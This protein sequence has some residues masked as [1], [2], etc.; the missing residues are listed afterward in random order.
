VFKA[1]AP[2]PAA[3]DR[4]GD[5]QLIAPVAS[6]GMA[7]VWAAQQVSELPAHRLVAIK[8]MRGELG[9]DDDARRMFLD[10]GR[11]AAC[12]HHPNIC[13]VHLIGEAMG[14]SYLVMEWIDGIALR[15][16]Q[17]PSFRMAATI[18]ANVCKGLHYAHE[19]K[20]PQGVA[21][22]LVHRDVTPH[23]IL[24]DTQGNVKLAD[25]GIAKASGFSRGTTELGLLK[26]KAGY[27]PPELLDGRPIDRRADIFALGCV[28]FELT[29]GVR[30]F[31]GANDI[32]VL[33]KTIRGVVERP[34]ALI[35]NYPI[36]LER[37]VLRALAA[38]P[39]RR[40]ASALDMGSELAAWLAQVGGWATP[41]EIAGALQSSYGPALTERRESLRQLSVDLVESPRPR[42]I[43]TSAPTDAKTATV[44]T[45]PTRRRRV[46]TMTIVAAS[47]AVL[48]TAAVAAK[49]SALE[50]TSGSLGN[51]Q[52]REPLHAL[53]TARIVASSSASTSTSTDATPAT[54]AR[55]VAGRPPGLLTRPLGPRQRPDNTAF[56]PG[57]N[58][59][60]H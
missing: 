59:Y 18:V 52:P 48:L 23:N 35:P 45:A 56:V 1:E 11:L 2:Q 30:T 54:T 22:D 32:E 27:M 49:V 41:D 9:V 37:I 36:E 21:L 44:H 55:P 17:K 42:N 3:G 29:T 4:Y 43:V 20:S 38:D 51:A 25:F 50:R 60:D 47:L 5:F 8:V 19:V 10:E 28:L 13:R 40:Y 33:K 31:A 24:I 15:A 16:L 12:L 39:H 34:S 7:V 57:K 53:R 46:H 58:P 6:G 14:N 26:G